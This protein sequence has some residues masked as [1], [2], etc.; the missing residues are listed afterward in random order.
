MKYFILTAVVCIVLGFGF[1]IWHASGTSKASTPESVLID[2][3]L[4]SA[5]DIRKTHADSIAEFIE[6]YE[7]MCDTMCSLSK[8][9]EFQE[10]GPHMN[11]EM[12]RRFS[13]WHIKLMPDDKKAIGNSFKAKLRPI[14]ELSRAMMNDMDVLD[15]EITSE[16]VDRM[17]EMGSIGFDIVMDTTTYLDHYVKWCVANYN[18]PTVQ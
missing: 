6:W 10:V 11:E 16:H 5:T 15:Y 7:A 12:Y 1:S 17:V 14:C 9:S 3:K 13:T 8:L 2:S 4:L 18:P